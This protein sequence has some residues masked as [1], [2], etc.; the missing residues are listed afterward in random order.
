MYLETPTSCTE[1]DYTQIFFITTF[2]FIVIAQY[3]WSITLLWI[4]ITASKIWATQ[5]NVNL[6][7][8]WTID[9]STWKPDQDWY[10]IRTWQKLSPTTRANTKATILM[11]V[12]IAEYYFFLIIGV[13][14]LT[15]L[16]RLFHDG[17]DE[18]GLTPRIIE[19]FGSLDFMPGRN[20][21]RQAKMWWANRAFCGCLLWLFRVIKDS[22]L[23]LITSVW[24]AVSYPL[25]SS[26][27]IVSHVLE[28]T[29]EG[30]AMRRNTTNETDWRP[31]V[32]RNKI[33]Y[34]SVKFSNLV[35]GTDYD[36][37]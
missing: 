10:P 13:S 33:N 30:W 26:W 19:N 32:P 2:A 28:N 7:Q 8:R 16:G 3:S 31:Y 5:D 20:G 4:I 34:D 17:H 12:R 14:F 36:D 1:T 27:T 11:L 24:A 35:Q 9:L 37:D 18:I 25:K 23:T 29:G 6:H 15:Q 22:L 21:A